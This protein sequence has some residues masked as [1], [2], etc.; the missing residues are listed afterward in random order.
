MEGTCKRDGGKVARHVV[1]RRLI[2]K[3]LRRCGRVVTKKVVRRKDEAPLAGEGKG[4]RRHLVW[5]FA[6]YAIAYVVVFKKNGSIF[7]AARLHSPGQ[8]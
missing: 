6:V 5:L 2:M 1:M 3:A 7:P 4:D 8:M